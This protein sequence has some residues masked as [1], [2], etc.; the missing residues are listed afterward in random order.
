MTTAKSPTP[1]KNKG[2][3]PKGK[4][5]T[6]SKGKAP[7]TTNKGQNVSSAKSGVP[8]LTKKSGIFYSLVTCW[9]CP[10]KDRIQLLNV[11][12]K[13]C[14]ENTGLSLERFSNETFLI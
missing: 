4:T 5:V 6:P 3:V 1:L 9:N 13:K 12:L 7:T 10:V 14:Q 11:A 2:T 8:P